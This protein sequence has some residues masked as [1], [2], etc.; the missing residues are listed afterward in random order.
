MNYEDID[1]VQEAQ[2]LQRLVQNN[3]PYVLLLLLLI[4]TYIS[5]C[6]LYIICPYY[7]IFLI[8]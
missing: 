7:P 1:P 6:G 3:D 8:I 5:I 4:N 2:E